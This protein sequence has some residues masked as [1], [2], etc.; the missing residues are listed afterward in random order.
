MNIIRIILGLFALVFL[1]NGCEQRPPG[2]SGSA[3]TTGADIKEDTSRLESRAEW[4]LATVEEIEPLDILPELAPNHVRGARLYDDILV[5]AGT[6]PDGDNPLI[7]FA[8][9]NADLAGADGWRCS[10]CHGYDFEGR[11]FLG[12]AAN[13]LLEL[14]EV[15]GFTDEYVYVAITEG[16]SIID[17]GAIVNVHNYS[18]LLTDQQR[19]DLADFVANETFD[20][21]IYLKAATGGTASIEFGDPVYGEELWTGMVAPVPGDGGS[22]LRDV[23]G[24]EFKCDTCH[25]ADGLLVA[26][27]DVFAVAKTEPWRFF[28]RVLFGSPR[29]GADPG[30]DDPTVM[31]GLYEIVQVNGLHFGGPEQGAALLGYAQSQ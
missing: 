25:G 22:P 1:L 5:E 16:F 7:A 20:T 29:A 6:I 9:E 23:R 3:I 30:V 27:K 21:H 24:V 14:S 12:G 15:R 26:G 11:E 2:S 10:V 18:A 28:F 13:N 8:A 31:P 19:V 4:R 17:G